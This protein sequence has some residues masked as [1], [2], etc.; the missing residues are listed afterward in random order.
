M[1]TTNIGWCTLEGGGDAS[2]GFRNRDLLK[3]PEFHAI[4]VKPVRRAIAAKPTQIGIAASLTRN[5]ILVR[6]GV[7]LA[8]VQTQDLSQIF[9]AILRSLVTMSRQ[10]FAVSN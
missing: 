2:T 5:A 9:Y 4:A 3:I 6:R 7:V 1:G 10:F 8:L